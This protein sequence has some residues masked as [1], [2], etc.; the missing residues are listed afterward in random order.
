[1]NDYFVLTYENYSA[2]SY[3]KFSG[4]WDSTFSSQ[5]GYTW[6]RNSK[7]HA[8]FYN[9]DYNW[10]EIERLCSVGAVYGVYNYGNGGIYL[11]DFAIVGSYSP[12]YSYASG[13]ANTIILKDGYII[14]NTTFDM[15]SSWNAYHIKFDNI[16]VYTTYDDTVI[17][18]SYDIVFINCVFDHLYAYASSSSYSGIYL[19]TPASF[20]NC[21]W[22]DTSGS[23]N[24]VLHGYGGEHKFFNCLFD[25]GP[26]ISTSAYDKF[27]SI[28]HNQTEN[29]HLIYLNPYDIVEDEATTRHTASGISW[30]MT[31][32]ASTRATSWFP[33]AFSIAQVACGADTQVTVSVYVKRQTS[34]VMTVKLVCPAY[35]IADVDTNVE[36]SAAASDG[37]WEQLTINFTPGEAG[38]VDIQIHAYGASESVY[39]DDIS[40]TQA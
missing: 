36:D 19:Y 14:G 32:G 39:I 37:S 31:L 12:L 33:T 13:V 8:A 11:H 24:D 29:N 20:Y 26:S 34:S 2:T 23:V 27:I 21:V 30:K 25:N 4:G 3:P 9:N 1:M 28:K 6:L 35:Q 16:K 15:T 38:V 10:I 18:R 40:I 17:D 5:T 7:A 22:T